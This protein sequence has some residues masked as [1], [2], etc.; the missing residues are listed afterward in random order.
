MA[1][2][3]KGRVKRRLAA[4]VAAHVLLLSQGLLS[5]AAYAQQ[6]DKLA[7]VGVLTNAPLTPEHP[8]EALRQALRDLGYVEGKNITFVPKSA[9]GNVDLFPELARELAGANVS[10][11]VVAGDQGLRAAKEATTTIP[12]VALLCDMPDHLMA[13]ISRPGGKATAVSCMSTDLAAKRV[14][15]LKEL[16]PALVNIAALYNPGDLRA[17]SEYK[18]VQEAAN[19]L[20]LQLSAYE[21]RSGTEI[22][23]TFALIAGKHPQALVIFGDVLMN[24]HLKTLAD[25]T[26]RNRLPAIYP[27]REFV[28]MGGLISY[29]ASLNG[30]WRRAAPYVDKI[31]KGADPGE[32]P[33]DQPTRFEL[34]INLSTAKM[35]GIEV[36]ATLLIRADE[37]IEKNAPAVSWTR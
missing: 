17:Q 34:V 22:E 26:L 4:I 33:I 15:L 2:P 16:V 10:V 11:M 21:A 19:S 5:L 20:D 32:L 31:L 12:I 3:G 18:Q 36:P 28:D 7:R 1:A 35:L 37:L 27:I 30:Q 14:Q 8:Y 9:Q 6:A 23:K 25:L 29:G 13:S 24:V